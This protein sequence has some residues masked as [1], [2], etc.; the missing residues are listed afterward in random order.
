[1][2]SVLRNQIRK[3]HLS[4]ALGTE[5]L[6]NLVHVQASFRALH[7]LELADG[8][9]FVAHNQPYLT[10]IRLTTQAATEAAELSLQPQQAVCRAR[11]SA[12]PSAPPLMPA[13]AEVQA[14]SRES[15]W[16]A[17]LRLA[18]FHG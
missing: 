14:R 4:P 6:G 15:E 11:S 9:V 12:G 17:R 7:L 2:N 1:M 8:A 13:V 10:L 18:L 5:C 3:N 16:T